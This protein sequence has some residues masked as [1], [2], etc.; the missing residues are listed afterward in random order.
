MRLLCDLYHFPTCQIFD[1]IFIYRLYR[2]KSQVNPIAV[3]Q[4]FDVYS[5]NKRMVAIF[6]SPEFGK[7]AYIMIG[8]GVKMRYIK[9]LH[10]LLVSV[11]AKHFVFFI[12]CNHG[13]FNYPYSSSWSKLEKVSQSILLLLR[14]TWHSLKTIDFVICL[15][16]FGCK[17]YY[18]SGAMKSGISPLEVRQSSHYLKRVESR[19]TTIC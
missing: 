9:L 10:S 2:L 14:G 4:K 3:R 16:C 5:Q 6:D 15:K 7:V 1:F 19:S 11:S 12:R 17:F 8:E 13:G 18:L